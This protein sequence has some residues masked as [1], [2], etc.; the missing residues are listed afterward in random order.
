M[1]SAGPEGGGS[2]GPNELFSRNSLASFVSYLL[3]LLCYCPS[4]KLPSEVL[5]IYLSPCS[6]NLVPSRSQE[7]GSWVIP[8][9]PQV[10][11]GGTWLRRGAQL[12][13]RE[14]LGSHPCCSDPPSTGTRKRLSACHAVSSESVILWAKHA[15]HAEQWDLEEG[16]SFRSHEFGVQ[17]MRL[18]ALASLPICPS[19]SQFP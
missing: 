5:C 13:T 18:Q 12:S 3:K 14:T 17:H 4:L 6:E 7:G 11:G 1:G 15:L 2:L 16:R 10:C 19:L 8:V 9:S